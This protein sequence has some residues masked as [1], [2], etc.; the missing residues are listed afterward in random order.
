MGIKLTIDVSRSDAII[1]ICDRM[2]I[3]ETNFL[4]YATNKHL[5]TILEAVLNIHSEDSDNYFDNFV[6][7]DF[8]REPLT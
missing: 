6:V 1:R 2:E 3:Q 4:K 5:E 7:I 8:P